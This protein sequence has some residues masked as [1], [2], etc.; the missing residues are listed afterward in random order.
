LT[1]L[2]GLTKAHV[3]QLRSGGIT[4]LA[5]LANLSVTELQQL[6][7]GDT[8]AVYRRWLADAAILTSADALPNG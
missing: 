2:R 7:P 6:V 4:T 1:Q 3:Q 5:Q 8:L